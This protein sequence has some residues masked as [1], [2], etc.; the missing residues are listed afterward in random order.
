MTISPSSPLL[1]EVVASL[2]SHRGAYGSLGPI[3]SPHDGGL[4]LP[5][6]LGEVD[7]N[8]ITGL[9]PLGGE[10]DRHRPIVGSGGSGTAVRK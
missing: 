3:D 5:A 10:L 1:D 4:H 9:K 8:D 7:Q 6:L 2:H